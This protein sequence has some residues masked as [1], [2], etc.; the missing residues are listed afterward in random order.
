MYEGIVDQILESMLRGDLKPND[1]LPS[2]K[3]MADM[4]G[5]SRVTVREAIL[6]LEQYGVIEVRQGSMGGAYIREIDLN[7]VA[8][9][10]VNALRMTNVTFPHLAEARAV[11]EEIIITRMIATHVSKKN[12]ENLEKTVTKAENHYK[13]NENKERLLTNFKF[14]TLI[15]EMTGNPIIIL[16]HKL[17][18]DLSLDFY[19]NVKPTR[20]MIEKTHNDHRKVV[21]L[22]RQEKFQEAG[23]LC[24]NHIRE[25]SQQ[26]VAKSK[27]QS[28]LKSTL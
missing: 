28:L 7:A 20:P 4:L 16:M 14:H 22:L 5:V 1:K 9:Q 13:K 11:I 15:A 17:I 23:H 19:E 27:R 21:K 2:E 6:S 12:L 10:I 8:G 18:V 25:V 24:S 3:E 26:I